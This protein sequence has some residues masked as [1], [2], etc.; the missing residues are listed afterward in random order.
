MPSDWGFCDGEGDENGDH[1][2]YVNGDNCP[3]LQINGPSGRTYA[4][5]L[6]VELQDWDLVHNDPRYLAD[7]KP[8]WDATGTADCGVFFGCNR[9]TW[10]QII[11]RTEITEQEFEQYAQCCYRRNWTVAGGASPNRQ[12]QAVR[13]INRWISR[14]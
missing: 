12:R 10:V 14:S 2:C 11:G 3:H 7:V 9:E 6:F 13:A 4:C 1:C 8:H 5:A